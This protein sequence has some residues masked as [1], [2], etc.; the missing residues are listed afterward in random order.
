MLLIINILIHIKGDLF[1]WQSNIT[2]MIVTI[3][4]NLIFGN[5]DASKVICFE[6]PD[7]NLMKNSQPCLCLAN[8][9]N[10]KNT[11]FKELK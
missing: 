4:T 5:S 7:G 6:R 11:N 9:A 10:R 8:Q 3:K 1:P 2:Q